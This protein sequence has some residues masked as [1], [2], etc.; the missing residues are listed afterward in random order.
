MALGKGIMFVLEHGFHIHQMQDLLCIAATFFFFKSPTHPS[1]GRDACST[2]KRVALVAPRKSSFIF[3]T[4]ELKPSQKLHLFLI[5]ASLAS[6]L[7][8][9]ISP[10]STSYFIPAQENEVRDERVH[11]WG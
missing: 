3:K 8:S 9:P 1:P 10:S 5:H 11:T 7:L 4:G 6:V 2:C